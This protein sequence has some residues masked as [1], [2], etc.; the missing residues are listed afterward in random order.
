MFIAIFAVHPPV[1]ET[2]HMTIG[3]LPSFP[4]SAMDLF[5]VFPCVRPRGLVLEIAPGAA[6]A[7]A[8]GRCGHP[9][10][11]RQELMIA[12][13]NIRLYDSA[14]ATREP[15]RHRTGFRPLG[16]LGYLFHRSLSLCDMC[17]RKKELEG[18]IICPCSRTI[19]PGDPV[20]LVPTRRAVW[21][22]REHGDELAPYITHT[23]T[24]PGEMSQAV[25]SYECA[26]LLFRKASENTS[27]IWTGTD[28]IN[29][30][31]FDML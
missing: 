30:S 24:A 23:M 17:R 16:P 15:R 31:E 6:C 28:V 11:T 22:A 10:T 8:I 20:V 14:A 12:G 18:T 21:H 4:T 1:P 19:T 13:T 9:I 27:F 26:T 3:S 2:T 29:T 5:N 7:R 25:M